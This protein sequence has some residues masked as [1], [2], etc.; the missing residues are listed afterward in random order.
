MQKH[1]SNAKRSLFLFAVIVVLGC[2]SSA[3]AGATIQI[4]NQ[5]GAGEGFNDPTPAAPVGGNAGTTLGQQRLIAFQHAADIW[6][7][8]LDSNQIIRIQAAFNPLAAGV[9]GS[10][11][12]I[13]AFRDFGGVGSNP[14]AE[15]PGTWYGGALANKRAGADLNPAANDINAQFSSNFNFYLGL[16]NNHGPLNDLVVV[17]LH[18]FSHGLNFQTFVNPTTGGNLGISPTTPDGFPDI[19]GRRILDTTIGLHYHE[20]TQVQRQAAA[21]KFGRIVFDSP[22]VTANV[23]NVLVFGSPD[24]RVNSPAA[25]A[26]PYQ[27]GTAGFGPPLGSP[28]VTADVVEAVDPADAAGPAT[29]DGCSAFTNAAAVAGKIALIERGTCGFAQK[30]R[31]ANNAGAAAFIIY[32]NAANATAG[33]PGM[34]DD[35]INGAFVFI[36]GA[37][38][39]RTDG[40]GIV[41]QLGGGVNAS[42]IVDLTVRAGADALGRARLFA[43]NPVQGG[44]SISHYDSVARRNLLM[45]PAIN[46]DLTH[47]VKSPDDLTLELFRDVGWFADSDLDGVPNDLTPTTLSLINESCAPANSQIDPGERV[48]VSLN[49]TNNGASTTNLVATL[50][51][52]GGVVSPSGPQTYGVIAGGGTKSVD[53]SFTASPSVFPGQTIIATLQLQDGASNRGSV[54]FLFTAGPAPCGGVRLVVKST[55]ARTDSS[56]VQATI[57]V[58]NIG[59]LPAD[60][61]TLTTAKLGATNGTPLPQSLGSIGPGSSA[62]TTV[63]FTNS[64]PGASSTLSAGGTYT[65][66]TF[67]GTKRVT[68]P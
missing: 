1:I 48:T 31:N 7:A 30:A 40:L 45:E 53:F 35:G 55:L 28:S 52:A 38:L 39:S 18:E 23:P 12:S 36:P 32:N 37:S 62:S 29:N 15:F 8:T 47:N 68:V 42:L 3:F 9:L 13:Q 64:T 20:M 25:I 17:L 27:F 56:T 33:P 5:D 26:G 2:S 61:T 46:G 66:G 49:L 60:A 19:Y 67:S 54:S 22:T 51:S 4:I 63:N 41:A 44:S 6:G 57:T 24:V 11:G 10:A 16:D 58:E 50:Q 14:G 43:P 59:T 21:V 34:G 65:G